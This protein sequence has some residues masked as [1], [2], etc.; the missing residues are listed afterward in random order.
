MGSGH[1]YDPENRLKKQT[2]SD[3]AVT[4]SLYEGD[5]LRRVKITVSVRST[6]VWDGSDYLGEYQ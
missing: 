4:T 2:E 5:G 1:V 3:G 6:H